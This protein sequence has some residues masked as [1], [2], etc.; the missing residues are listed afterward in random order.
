VLVL[1]DNVSTVK[2]SLVARNLA[3]ALADIARVRVVRYWA[4][5]EGAP[6]PQD[7][8]FSD[9][10]DTDG[11][12]DN[13]SA[14]PSGFGPGWHCPPGPPGSGGEVV[15][16]HYSSG[17]LPA[18]LSTAGGG[19]SSPARWALGRPLYPSVPL[20]TFAAGT[21]TALG[22]A[23]SLTGVPQ[24]VIRDLPPPRTLA[25]T[26][27]PSQIGTASLVHRSPSYIPFVEDLLAVEEHEA[28]VLRRR[29]RLKRAQDVAA[30]ARRHS[31]RLAAREEP[32]YI[33]ATSKASRVKAAQLDLACASARMREAL[34]RSGVLERPAPRRSRRLTSA[35]WG[36]PVACLAS[37]PPATTP[38]PV[39]CQRLDD[40][41]SVC[42]ACWGFSTRE[43]PLAGYGP[44]L[45]VRAA[46]PLLGERLSL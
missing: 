28:S 19:P 20:W 17:G 33:D 31:L 39:W 43:I 13:S 26:A 4:H 11:G 2:P 34:A 8:E 36:V 32:F 41:F 9:W 6:L 38:T 22:R 15:A 24:L 40:V 42:V 30:K 7:S 10:G 35:A 14:G 44:V 5:P 21:L 18:G 3:G 27:P 23:L 46:H 29:V 12:N 1:L 45:H 37:P 25:S 16:A